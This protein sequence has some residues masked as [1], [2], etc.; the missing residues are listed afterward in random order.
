MLVPYM[1]AQVNLIWWF[2][3]S[4]GGKEALVRS[5][6]LSLLDEKWNIGEISSAEQQSSVKGKIF[7]LEVCHEM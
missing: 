5:Q 4:Q 6:D 1:C 7:T 3:A 2:A